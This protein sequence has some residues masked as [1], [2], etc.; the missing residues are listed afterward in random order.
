V[1]LKVEPHYGWGWFDADRQKIPVPAPFELEAQAVVPKLP[2]RNAVLGLCQA[3]SH[4]LAGL[5]ILL[6]YRGPGRTDLYAH[7]E[8]PDPKVDQLS[9]RPKFVGNAF[10]SEIQG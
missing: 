9:L 1:K 6:C 3:N 8:E 7:A 2:Y 10:T 5:W 4:P